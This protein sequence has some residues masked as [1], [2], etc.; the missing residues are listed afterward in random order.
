MH[1]DDP[2]QRIAELERELAAQKRIAEL[3][4]QLAEAKATAGQ[5]YAVEQPHQN[6]DAPAGAGQ[7]GPD[8]HARRY[9][10]ALLEELRIGGTPGPDSPLGPEMAG[11]REAL[12]RAAAGA[13]MSEA[14]INDALQHATVTIKSGHAVVYPEQGRPQNFGT[15]SR[16]A[17]PPAFPREAD[18]SSQGQGDFGR[19]Q[20]RRTRY[21][22][23]DFGRI[24]GR[25]GMAIGICVSGSAVLTAVLPSSALWTSAILCGG[26][27]Q[28]LS[29]T[30]HSS[31]GPG[32]SRSNVSFQCVGGDGAYDA[33]FFAI[34]GLQS[35]LIALVLGA[36]AAAGV[37]IRNLLRRKPI[38]IWNAVIVG[39]LVP[40]AAA[41]VIA[42][43]WQAL[44]SSNP[45]QMAKGGTLTVTGNG[46]SQTV[47]CNDGYLTVHGRDLTVTVRGH[48]ARLTVDGV[49]SHVTVDSADE[50]KVD[51]VHNAVIFHSGSPDITSNGQNTVRQG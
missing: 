35:L 11:L 19:Q 34:M 22:A 30:S 10:Q 41:V 13:G 44:T 42:T 7:D 26:P 40:L 18:F 27:N 48:C 28:L 49:I 31:Y 29:N 46:A 20:P 38:R 43:Q 2:E 33:N 37:L 50:I 14:Q 32:T 36:A 21:G 5:N 15:A 39:I 4:R 45:I 24:V 51:G 6:S 12:T 3:E 47:A 17:P 8:E 9:A 16:V 1:E 25:A 23:A